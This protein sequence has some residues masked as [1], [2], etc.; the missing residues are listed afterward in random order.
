MNPRSKEVFGP[1]PGASVLR[2][3]S[4]L[5]LQLLLRALVL[6]GAAG[7]ACGQEQR[8]IAVLRAGINKDSAPRVA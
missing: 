7:V 1:R 5:A 8:L 4:S 6:C 3:A 2:D